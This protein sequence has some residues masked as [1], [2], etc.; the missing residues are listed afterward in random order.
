MTSPRDAAP[1]LAGRDIT[2]EAGKGWLPMP[3]RL[4][5]GHCAVGAGI[6][7]S[8]L[9]G[10]GAAGISAPALTTVARPVPVTACIVSSGS[11][12]VTPV[13]TATNTALRAIKVGAHPVAMA[14]T[15]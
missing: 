9:A 6:A 15:P 3:G 1:G 7:A 2:A 11:G 10:S 5:C 12:T 14:I 4:V 13:R 8:G